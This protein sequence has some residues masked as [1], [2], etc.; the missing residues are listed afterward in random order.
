MTKFEK[1]IAESVAFCEKTDGKKVKS[2]EQYMEFTRRYTDIFVGDTGD[3]ED[4]PKTLYK[5]YCDARDGLS[6]SAQGRLDRLANNFLRSAE[7]RAFEMGAINRR[8]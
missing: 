2:P 3:A 4:N 1:L 6:A 8:T 5:L 7:P